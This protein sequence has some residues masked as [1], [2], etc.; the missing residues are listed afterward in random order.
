MTDNTADMS[1]FD[2]PPDYEPDPL[3]LCTHEE[4]EA[5]R[6]LRLAAEH[7]AVVEDDI[8]MWKWVVI[9]LHSAV[10]A[11]LVL[12]LRG[13]APGR[14][15]RTI[16][17][18]VLR[19][20]RAEAE[21]TMDFREWLRLQQMATFLELYK[22]FKRPD[23]MGMYIHSK[24]FS[25]KGSVTRSIKRLNATRNQFIHFLP[26]TL[27]EDVR[28]LPQVVLDACEVVQ[29]ATFESGNVYPIEEHELLKRTQ[30]LLDRISDRA[31]QLKALHDKTPRG[32]IG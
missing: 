11:C 3:E 17:V 19:E 5:L 25:P 7:L 26:M 6:S 23:T 14:L 8:Y 9:T 22:R 28:G 24:S 21:R 10:E 27:L 12:A 29:F 18:E 2:T 31:T 15:L 4:T 30:V 16:D 32:T 1:W 13:T 20:A